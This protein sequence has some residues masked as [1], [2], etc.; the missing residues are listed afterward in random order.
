MRFSP[1]AIRAKRNLSHQHV[2]THRAEFV[3]NLAES[4]HIGGPVFSALSATSALSGF[5]FLFL[6]ASASRY[7]L[8]PVNSLLLRVFLRV[9]CA[10]ASRLE[11][12]RI[13]PLP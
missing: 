10:S 11:S 2:S 1:E 13:A 12:S 4:L 6:G 9:L 5:G 7:P 3:L 8:G